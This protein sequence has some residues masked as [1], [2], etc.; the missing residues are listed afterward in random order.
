MEHCKGAG[1]NRSFETTNY[2]IKTCPS[3]E[4]KLILDSSGLRVDGDSLEEVYGFDYGVWS[5]QTTVTE[6]LVQGRIFPNIRKLK[7]S[8]TVHSAKLKDC[9]ILAVVLY[10][11]PMVRNYFLFDRLFKY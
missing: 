6:L 10:T 3:K 8:D 2:G 11:G 7:E 5:T 9:E 4:W 1:S